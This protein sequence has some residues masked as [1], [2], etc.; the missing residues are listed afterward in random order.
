M[1]A[2]VEIVLV[3]AVVGPFLWLLP[4][5]GFF[6]DATDAAVDMSSMEYIFATK[7]EDPG[8]VRRFYLSTDAAYDRFVHIC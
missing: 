8:F 5:V 7:D 2:V 3:V 4:R 1:V 6:E